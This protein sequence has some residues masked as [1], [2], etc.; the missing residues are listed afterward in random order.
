MKVLERLKQHF[1]LCNILA[2]SR[3]LQTGG[4]Y[5]C[6]KRSLTIIMLCITLIPL[7]VTSALS[8]YQYHHLLQNKAMKNMY[9]HGESAR[10]SLEVFL[11]TIKN[12]LVITFN[13]YPMSELA[14][15]ERLEGIFKELKKEHKGLVD[16]SVLGPD[17]IQ[18]A[19]AG[20]YKLAGKNYIS[21]EWYKNTLI[22]KVYISDMIQ[23]FRNVPHFVIAVSKKNAETNQDWVLR[24][25]INSKT[26]DDFFVSLAKE[27]MDDI[28]LLN[29]DG[30]LQNTSRSNGSV[31][32]NASFS[33]ATWLNDL[34]VTH[35]KRKDANVLR[36]VAPVQ[37]TSWFL[38]LEQKDY[39]EQ[40]NW[41]SFRDQLI[42]ILL[43]TVSLA[44][45]A[46]VRIATVLT[47][48]IREAD[49]LRESFLCEQ[50]HTNKL[51]SI[52]RLAAGVAH[53]INN[54]LAIINEKA[55]LLKD[56]LQM[57]SS[58]EY[59]DKFISQLTSLEKAVARA[60]AIT[61]RLLGFARRTD[62][63]LAPVQINDVIREV[64][65]FL[66]KEVLYRNISI[67]L[68]LREG[69]PEFKSDRGQLQ[70]I[71]L[72]ILNNAIDAID[73]N[74]NISIISQQLTTSRIKVDIRDDGPGMESDVLK[75]IFEPF[76]STKLGQG[77]HGTGLGL[78]ITYGLMKKLGG[79]IYVESERGAGTTFTLVFPI[80]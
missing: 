77:E 6:L 8:F 26:I 80:T 37:G 56:I 14:S 32:E 42:I 57:S 72:N 5:E 16:L 39:A 69:L 28:F 45:V 65:E 7:G 46:I 30:M 25:S 75:K 53:E 52:G 74:G 50:E 78:S 10:Y 17:G 58:F 40:Q 38:I 33:V 60:R 20:P 48:K 21:S 68:N 59:R 55:G 9:W 64:F 29:K 44:W 18:V 67:D 4:H 73:K 2:L 31:G 22:H 23:G 34:V 63:A 41:Y 76:F 3:Q 61:H 70:Q 27:P 24:A 1:L 13:S 54:P 19:Y 11:E 12:A 47:E 43:L 66:N 62:V 36:A 15:Q 51:A 71:L 49:M 79:E 35:E